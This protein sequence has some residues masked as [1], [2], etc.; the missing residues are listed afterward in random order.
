VGGSGADAV[1]SVIVHEEMSASD[2][3]FCLAYLAHSLLFVNNLNWNGSAEQ[4]ARLIPGAATG[5]LLGGMCMS[6]PG[7]GTDVL[8]MA[9]SYRRDGGDYVLNGTK[10]WITNGAKDEA[11]TGD[12]FLL[13]ARSNA[14][15][16]PA[17]S[18]FL[19]EKGMPGFSLG[20]R[21]RDKCGMVRHAAHAPRCG[22][23]NSAPPS[24]RVSP[25][26]PHPCASVPPPASLVRLRS[27][28]P[29]RRSWCL[30]TCACP[31]RRTWWAPRATRCYA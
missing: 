2:P 21:I 6:E 28:P 30:T 3:A 14:G 29:T 18:L 7:A 10:M 12:A 9:T 25:A 31:R 16:K 13:Y 22:G 24:R 17:F 4:K 1:S 20:T 27:A 15:P 5:E 11:T 8:G 19:V 26:C 23:G